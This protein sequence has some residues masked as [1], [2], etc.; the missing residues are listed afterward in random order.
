M[1]IIVLTLIGV[2]LQ[3]IEANV[4]MMLV[5]NLEFLKM[6]TMFVLLI[7]IVQAHLEEKLVPLIHRNASNVPLMDIV[8]VIILLAMLVVKFALSV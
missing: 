8:E 2:I 6:M 5:S 3:A 1:M 7:Q 4:L